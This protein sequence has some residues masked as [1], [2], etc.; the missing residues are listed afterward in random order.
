MRFKTGTILIRESALLPTDL[1]FTRESCVPGWKIVTDS[2]VCA[3]DEEIRKAG[4]AFFRIASEI[5][6]S[7]FGLDEQ[8]MLRRAIERILESAKLERFNSVQAA[9]VRSVDFAA[10][11]G[12]LVC[13]GLAPSPA[14]P[15]EP[16]P[17]CQVPSR[18]GYGENM[19][20]AGGKILCAADTRKRT[21]EQVREMATL[22]SGVLPCNDRRHSQGELKN[23]P[24]PSTRSRR[25]W[26]S[27][28]K[29]DI[30]CGE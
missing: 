11:P 15:A 3:L 1:A 18:I 25:G 28:S 2:D 7:V 14:Y 13:N 27:A 4:W 24:A 23:G 8:K 5:G 29:S 19:R 6:E 17:F 16:A 26:A 20:L 22:V 30:A 9:E 21:D 12:S 10:L